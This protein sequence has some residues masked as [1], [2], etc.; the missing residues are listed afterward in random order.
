MNLVSLAASICLKTTM[1]L[2][3]EEGAHQ[4]V[5]LEHELELK[6]TLRNRQTDV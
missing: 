1:R 6:R 2:L 3:V 4:A 5:T